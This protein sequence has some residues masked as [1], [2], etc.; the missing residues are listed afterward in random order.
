[1]EENKEKKC[2]IIRYGAWGDHIIASALYRAIK[3]DGYHL[4]LNTLPRGKD[5]VKNNPYIDELIIQEDNQILNEKL[6]EYWAEISKGYDKVIN[7]SESIEGQLLKVE[8]RP[9]FAWSKEKRHE[10]CNKNYYDYT[11]ELGGYKHITGK[12]GELFCSPIEHTLARTIRQKHKNKFLI[13]WGFSGSSFH[14][15][16]PFQEYVILAFVNKYP[17]S[18]VL[19]V[20]DGLCEVLG[21]P[22]PR[23]YYYSGKW[24][25][26]K[27][28]IM[29][30]YADLVVAT[31][32]GILNAAGCY[33]T[34]KIAILS[35][36]THENLTKYFKNVHPIHADVVCYPCHQIHYSLQSCPID[37]KLKSPL[38]MARLS[39]DILFKKMEEI[40]KNWRDRKYGVYDRPRRADLLC[41]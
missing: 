34:P 33:D 6:D 41:G 29:T 19:T 25:I 35:H 30:Q 27:T 38:C 20:G 37:E 16:Y 5:I 9:E 2:L 32:T 36:S 7:L 28:L 31:E 1:M 8:G 3:E 26:R 11:L 13:L 21:E 23:V 4:T 15:I 22:H 39:P 40:Y 10:E 12:T 18:I 24:G 14:K 17:D